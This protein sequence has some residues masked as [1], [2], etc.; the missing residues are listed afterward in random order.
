MTKQEKRLLWVALAIFAGYAIPFRLAPTAMESLK[1]YQTQQ[2]QHTMERGR[3]QRL[4]QQGEKWQQEHTHAQAQ[5]AA[6]EKALLQGENRELISAHLK[7]LLRT[8]ARK[9]K[10]DLKSL[11][12]SEF[13]ETDK[14]LFVT[15]KMQFEG[16]SQQTMALLQSIKNESVTLSIVSVDVRVIR[17]DRIQ[18]SITVTGFSHVVAEPDT[19]TEEG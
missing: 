10:T 15:Q 4:S 5:K 11:E 16:S 2:T 1:H 19:T 8:L 7:N 14:W 3:L 9:A 18:G 17:K 13:T 6:I 12:V